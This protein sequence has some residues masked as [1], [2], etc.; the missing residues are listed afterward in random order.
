MCRRAC[1]RH[2]AQTSAGVRMPDHR[3]TG[4]SLELKFAAQGSG[5]T[6]V[7]AGFSGLPGLRNRSVD[8]WIRVDC[9]ENESAPTRQMPGLR[10]PWSHA[11]SRGSE[12]P[13]QTP[14]EITTSRA[15]GRESI[16][17]RHSGQ[18]GVDPGASTGSRRKPAPVR[19]SPAQA[20]N[21]RQ[22][23][24]GGTWIMM[25]RTY[26]VDHGADRPTNDGQFVSSAR[27]SSPRVGLVSDRE[28]QQ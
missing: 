1:K 27:R 2:Q 26:G 14:G 5:W 9:G 17:E 28:D 3:L 19:A 10:A 4:S 12:T 24:A 18:T 16:S 20:G 23:Q 25:K 15:V 11:A 21:G 8:R 6:A 13:N 22:M 7:D